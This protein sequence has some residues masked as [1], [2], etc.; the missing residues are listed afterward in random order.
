VAVAVSPGAAAVPIGLS[1][2]FVATATYDDGSSADVTALAHWSSSLET[3][4]QVDDT[5]SKGVALGVAVGDARITAALDGVAGGADLTVNPPVL[6][7][8]EVV[9]LTATVAMHDVRPFAALGT[10]SDGAVR[11]VT[12]QATWSSS[13][14][15]IA[16]VSDAPGSRGIAFGIAAGSVAVG[17][18]LETVAGSAPLTVLPVTGLDVWV[19]GVQAT[20][21]G[22]VGV[23][24][25]G[26]VLAVWSHQ[27]TGSVF[28]TAPVVMVANH[29]PGADWSV[30][31]LDLGTITDP[32]GP[33]TIAVS[34]H[35]EA[36][37]AWSGREGVYVSR[38]T[39]AGGWTRARTL[40]TGT[41]LYLAYGEGLSVAIDEAGDGLIVW[42]DASGGAV[43]YS[44]FVAMTD[45]WTAAQEIPGVIRGMASSPLAFAMNASGAAVLL[46]ERWGDVSPSR[47]LQ[48]S[49]FV[50]GS[51]ASAGWAAP[52]PLSAP[53]S[54]PTPAVAI[55]G[56]GV[57]LAVWPSDSPGFAGPLLARRYT[58][59]VGWQAAERITGDAR[60]FPAEP[61]IAMN[62]AGDVLVTWR[63]AEDDSVRASR[64]TE[65]AGWETPFI[66]WGPPFFAHDT[67]TVY[68][69]HVTPEGRMLAGWHARELGMPYETGVRRFAPATG[70]GEPEWLTNVPHLGAFAEARTA[71]NAS[72]AGAVLWREIP[73][74]FDGRIFHNFGAIYADV[75]VSF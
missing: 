72:G 59:G 43:R 37:A 69:P 73:E 57:I 25:S 54:W 50:P 51:G 10:Y 36:L 49:R 29:A 64:R 3:V 9:S 32:P 75:G 41:P 26:N 7:S 38:Y 40:A 48:A 24:G 56:S 22:D 42:R 1:Q 34:A 27:F 35:G 2:P 58:P 60:V 16:Q 12:E 70:W 74:I 55:N 5:A 14:P 67:P 28:G 71:F 21:L 65:S 68:R 20:T 31:P 13:D 52:E 62:D 46:W 66:L 61:K 11:E 6:Q 4:A 53:D 23:D 19:P 39:P 47:T 44:R 30:A 45:S 8:I 33:T 17:A 63:S 18:S 15:G